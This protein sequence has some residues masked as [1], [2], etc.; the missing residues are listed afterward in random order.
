MEGF[1]RKVDSGRTFSCL[2]ASFFSSS[3]G[4]S[5]LAEVFALLYLFGWPHQHFIA[6]SSNVLTKCISARDSKLVLTTPLETFRPYQA[7]PIAQGVW[8]SS[9]PHFLYRAVKHTSRT[10]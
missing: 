7:H 10:V 1:L 4:P 3:L 8:H 5:F 6:T 9:H 2:L